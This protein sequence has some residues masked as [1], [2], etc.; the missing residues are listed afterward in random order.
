ME[1][2]ATVQPSATEAERGAR[3][4][5]LEGQIVDGC[6]AIRSEWMRLASLLYEMNVGQHYKLLDHDTFKS[7]LGSPEIGLSPSHAYALI[8]I[9]AEYVIAH[10]YTV[11]QLGAIDATKLAETL[12]ALRDG[13]DPDELIADATELSKSDLREKL[14]HDGDRLDAEKARPI[15]PNCQQRMPAK[16]VGEA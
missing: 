15:C 8:G 5:Q 9:H 7:W 13:G 10:G 11:E 16:K 1:E 14:G 3:A 2:I 6:R 12:P 4:Y